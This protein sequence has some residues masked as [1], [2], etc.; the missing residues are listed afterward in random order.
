VSL[1]EY[2]GLVQQFVQ[3]SKEAAAAKSK[4]FTGGDAM[5]AA[6]DKLVGAA[7]A[8]DDAASGNA[9]D[10]IE[11]AILLVRVANWRY[12]ATQDKGGPA[13]FVGNL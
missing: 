10:A 7:R 2:A 11:R 5:T 6:T 1:N 12:L 9:A 4:L 13:V 8:T 3:L